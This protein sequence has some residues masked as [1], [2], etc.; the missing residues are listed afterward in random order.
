MRMRARL[1]ADAALLV[2]ALPWC[3]ARPLARRVGWISGLAFAAASTAA[4]FFVPLFPGV[5]LGSVPGVLPGSHQRAQARYL[6][7]YA[8]RSR[9]GER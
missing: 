7:L 8:S 6:I 2:Q 1:K 9:V 5:L 3:S 4:I